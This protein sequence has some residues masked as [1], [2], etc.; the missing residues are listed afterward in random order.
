VV[1]TASGNLCKLLAAAKRSIKCITFSLGALILPVGRP[2]VRE[3]L[4]QLDHQ[5]KT[6]VKVVKDLVGVA[7]PKDTAMLLTRATD[8]TNVRKGDRHSFSQS[9]KNEVYRLHPHGDGCIDL[10]CLLVDMYTFLDAIFVAKVLVKID[11]GFTND[12]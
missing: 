9:V 12:F 6:R 5:G 11:L 8:T 10:A 7:I 1:G 2:L 3:C 4:R